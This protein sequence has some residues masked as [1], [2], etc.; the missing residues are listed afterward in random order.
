MFTELQ[1]AL[2]I[3]Y[4]TASVAQRRTRGR[5]DYYYFHSQLGLVQL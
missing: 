2:R 3:L 4:V 1:T 5:D